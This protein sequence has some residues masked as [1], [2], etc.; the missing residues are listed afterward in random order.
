MAS[1]PSPSRPLVLFYLDHLDCGGVERIVLNLL[2]GLS[3]RG[4]R[5]ALALNRAEGA[6]LKQ[7]PSAV[8]VHDLASPTFGSA[9]RALRRLLK[10][11]R[12]DIVISQRAYLNVI[13]ALA[14]RASGRPGRL[15]LAEHMLLSRWQADAGSPK[16]PA[17]RLILA[18][19]PVA[20]RLADRVISVS[21]GVA[22]ELERRLRRLPG[23]V[24]VLYNP[25]VSPELLARAGGTPS[26]AP[27][28]PLFVAVGRLDPVKGFDRL[29]SA[30]AQ[31]SPEARLAIIGEGPE[32]GRLEA[33]IARLGLTERVHLP[34][35]Q[36][37]PYAWMR[38]ARALVLSSRF[39]TFPTVLVEAMAL[40][41]P[42]VAVDC[43][44]GPRE[45]ITPE[46]D[47][48]LVPPEDP[49][50]LARAM[51]RLIRDEAL[52]RRLRAG[53][54]RRAEAFTFERTLGAYERLFASLCPARPELDMAV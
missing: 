28:P 43:P 4:W 50:A 11:A 5:L 13:A 23:S 37:D 12:P 52:H 36:A 21:R 44:E 31:V 3:R 15:V 10:E 17:D 1:P 25:I 46:T 41:V 54:L 16:R 22:S 19:L 27:E 33:E 7:L 47:G 48:L 9:F 29:L 24:P 34:G 40:G 8:E 51:E 32:R 53:G 26:P 42:V 18:L 38:G 45:I 6:F 49:A 30:F 20:C 2:E 14:H 35:Y 39:E